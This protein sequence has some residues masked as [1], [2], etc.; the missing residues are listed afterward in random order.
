MN[1][2]TT[3]S[4][5][6]ATAGVASAW[7]VPAKGIAEALKRLVSPVPVLVL[8]ASGLLLLACNVTERV[9]HRATVFKHYYPRAYLF[10]VVLVVAGRLY[11][12]ATSRELLWRAALVRSLVVFGLLALLIGVSPLVSN[13]TTYADMASNYWQT[14]PTGSTS[15]RIGLPVLAHVIGFEKNG[16]VFFWYAVLFAS[17]AAAAAVLS[18]GR[19]FGIEKLS[20][21]SSSI[22]AYSLVGP[23]YSEVF[24]LLIGCCVILFETGPAEKIVAGALMLSTHETATAFT[25]LAIVVNAQEEERA[26]WLAVFALLYGLYVATYLFAWRG[27]VLQALLT[28][29]KPSPGAEETAPQLLLAHPLHGLLGIFLAYKL[30]WLLVPS[31]L[32]RP[33][34]R[35]MTVAIA[36]S[37][38]LAV[39]GTDTSRLVEFSTL[40]FL[41]VARTILPDW[42][43]RLRI[44]IAAANLAVPSLYVATNAE[45]L[46]GRGLYSAYLYG[47]R[48][49]GL[50]WGRPFASDD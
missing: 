18:R 36:A 41:I 43:T 3:T 48:E 21:L 45:P 30:Y 2:P 7:W 12:L 15:R 37:L 38:V 19:L 14:D 24:V 28:A 50:D 34:S 9:G 49:A 16:Y 32:R 47:A 20:L 44:V 35:P 26:D 46:W 23:G 1:P 27:E 25:A 42:P 31:G 13:G 8:S 39:I 11:Q 22:F 10:L 33:G 4:A 40:A 17:V 29:G 5:D 6:I